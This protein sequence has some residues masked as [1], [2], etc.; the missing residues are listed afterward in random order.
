M[1]TV[2]PPLSDH[3]NCK[4]MTGR[5]RGVYLYVE[6]RGSRVEGS[7]SRVESTKSRIEGNNFL[8]LFLK[9]GKQMENK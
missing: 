1:H 3:P 6:G 2:E 8:I 5:L 4:D 7:M 9:N